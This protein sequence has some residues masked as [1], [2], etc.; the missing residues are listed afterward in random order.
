MKRKQFSWQLPTEIEN[1]LGE[2]S[3]GRQRAIYEADHLLLILHTIPDE[4]DT[5]RDAIVFLRLP[6]GKW[7]CNG[8][9][10]GENQL[11][12]LLRSYHEK[13]Q[14]LENLYE[15]AKSAK[16]LFEIIEPL[17]PINRASLNMAD[18]I[19]SARNL[20]KDDQ[21]LIGIRDESEDISRSYEIMLSDTKMALDYRMAKN[22]E[23]QS[24][25]G[26]EMAEAQHKLNILAAITFPLMAMAAIFGMN[27]VHGL[28]EK[29]PILFWV[30][31]V[32]GIVIGMLTQ[33]W[34]TKPQ[35]APPH[36]SKKKKR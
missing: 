7:F 17:T 14:I 20:V 29:T 35:A 36:L 34:V 27:L 11:R 22:A 28:E 32:I 23:R 31:M 2:T 25:Q 26:Y 33:K 19:Q 16:E 30:V 18:A 9:D 1:R 3:Y 21:F 24:Q 8:R 13:Y 5:S 4:D 15:K 10:N 6:D 12:K